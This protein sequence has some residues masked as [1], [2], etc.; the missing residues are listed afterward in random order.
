MGIIEPVVEPEKNETSSHYLPH[1]GVVKDS[2][3]TTK[4]RPVFNA[5][6]RDRNGRSLN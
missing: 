4:L 6:A 1:R 3:L 2:S 5:S